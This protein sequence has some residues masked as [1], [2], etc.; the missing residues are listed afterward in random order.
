[1]PPLPNE[2]AMTEA[3]TPAVALG[4]ASTPMKAVQPQNS[5]A[6]SVHPDS[7]SD[8]LLDALKSKVLTVQ[9][10]AATVIALVFTVVISTSSAINDLYH[11]LNVYM[12]LLCA[13]APIATKPA[14]FFKGD[15]S[16]KSK[17]RQSFLVLAS[18][19]MI[20]WIFAKSVQNA[21]VL[22][23]KFGIA[24]GERAPRKKET[25]E[26]FE[27]TLTQR[28]PLYPLPSSSQASGTPLGT[29]PSHPS[30]PSCTSFA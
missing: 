30:L 23:A 27:T 5:K 3:K 16:G 14:T 12:W 29:S 28:P 21:S 20:S 11:V 6:P 2:N 17:T 25:S 10:A 22:G 26:R 1:M 13:F 19:T 15:I 9:F 4:A 18:S 24:G 7:L 8:R